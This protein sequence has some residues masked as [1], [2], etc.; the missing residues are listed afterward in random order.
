M[1]QHSNRIYQQIK[2]G[3]EEREENKQGNENYQRI[4][5]CKQSWLILGLGEGEE[6][7]EREGE[8]GFF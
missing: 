8:G 4:C 3:C 6:E 2:T 5:P 7:R 1:H